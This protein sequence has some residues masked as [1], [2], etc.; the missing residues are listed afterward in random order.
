MLF[1]CE[2]NQDLRPCQRIFIGS[3]LWS[4]HEI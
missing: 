3:M 1:I 2:I 4:G